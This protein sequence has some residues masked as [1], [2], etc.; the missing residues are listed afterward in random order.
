MK[1]LAIYLIRLTTAVK[2]TIVPDLHQM[3]IGLHTTS[4]EHIILANLLYI[5]L[6]ELLYLF[7]SLECQYLSLSLTLSMCNKVLK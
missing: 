7:Q 2:F 5:A 4:N 1:G 6:L 3:D